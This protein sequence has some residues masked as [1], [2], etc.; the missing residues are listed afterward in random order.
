MR[1]GIVMVAAAALAAAP[2]CAQDTSKWIV[3]GVTL[4]DHYEKLFETYDKSKAMITTFGYS[5][6][7]KSETS[8]RIWFYQQGAE[9]EPVDII[10]KYNFQIS[11]GNTY[12]S[13]EADGEGRITQMLFR[14]RSEGNA[15]ERLKLLTDRYGPYARESVGNYVW[16]CTTA[17]GPCLEGEPDQWK[18]EVRMQHSQ[19]M[20]DWQSRYRDMVAQTRGDTGTSRF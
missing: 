14:L 20:A 8:R 11:D 4:G 10:S 12:I 18:L 3:S 13:G 9:E 2:V 19:K 17:F 7:Y 1:V 16:G 6:Q 5:L 15:A